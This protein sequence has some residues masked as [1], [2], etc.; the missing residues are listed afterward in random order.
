MNEHFLGDYLFSESP[1]QLLIVG[2]LSDDLLSRPVNEVTV[3]RFSTLAKAEAYALEQKTSSDVD[4]EG[5]S[6][7]VMNQ[8]LDD[9]RFERRLGRA[10]RAFP[11][12]TLVHD[13]GARHANEPVDACFYALGFQRLNVN[14]TH[15][16]HDVTQ[17]AA[18]RWFEYRLSRYKVAPDWLNA[19]YWANPERYEIDEDPDMYCDDADDS[20]EYEDAE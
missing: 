19:R 18:E 11:Y 20:D 1:A 2:E 3:K 10:I 4:N 9:P 16:T 8:S 5:P 6:V 15:P 7:L 14:V 17:S 13:S 12:R